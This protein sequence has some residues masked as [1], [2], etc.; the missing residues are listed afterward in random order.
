MRGE[1]RVTKM[2]KTVKIFFFKFLLKIRN[3][4]Q[5]LHIL[6]N[7]KKN[8]SLLSLTDIYR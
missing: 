2:L 1:N 5:K 8:R 6:A 7:L 4:R 3:L